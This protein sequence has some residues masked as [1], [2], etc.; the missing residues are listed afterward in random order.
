VRRVAALLALLALAVGLA[1]CDGSGP[2]SDPRGEALAALPR[3]APF[4]ALVQTG[5]RPVDDTL[6]LVRSFPGG[7]FALA[8][9]EAQFTKQGLDYRHDVKPLLGNP[10]AIGLDRSDP[11]V[12]LVVRDE[13][14]L[15]RLLTQLVKRGGRRAGSY[16]DAGLYVARDGTVVARRGALVISSTSTKALRA[17]L[18]RVADSRGLQSNEFDQARQ[19]LPGD[20]LVT[21]TGRLDAL[22][23][24]PGAAQARRV[25]WVAAVRDYA[26]TLTGASDGVTM[27]ARVRTDGSKLSDADVPLAPGDAT[28]QLAQLPGPAVGVRDLAHVVAFAQRAAQAVNPTSFGDFERAK[29]QI[30]AGTGVDLDRD[31]VGQLA[32]DATV[33]L[34]PGNRVALRAH[35]RDPLALRRSLQR[36]E[37]V[38]ANGIAGAGALGARVQRVGPAAWRVFQRGR[39]IGAYA[40]SG[41]EFVAGNL[42]LAALRR[43][44]AAPTAPVPDAKGSVSV[45]VPAGYLRAFAQGQLGLPRNVAAAVLAKLGDLRGWV[46]SS[47]DQVRLTLRLDVH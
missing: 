27:D 32:S 12:A 37:R 4:A 47:K 6:A 7:N 3:D 22:L 45:R 1:A 10:V 17:A 16:R 39:L 15:G 11:V 9:A 44:A 25:P 21:A 41:S 20:A 36:L 5:G 26:F 42:D 33:T 35:A 30:R 2:S 24:R 34:A 14:A 43:V 46:S 40:V 23:R 8:G 31:I 38:A 29:A 18:N 13:D 19:G 28:S